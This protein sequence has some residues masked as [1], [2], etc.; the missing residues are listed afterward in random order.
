MGYTKR[1][2]WEI[3]LMQTTVQPT[4]QPTEPPEEVSGVQPTHLPILT[5]EE[6]ADYLRLPI[7]AVRDH[8]VQGLLPG[9][10]IQGEW[11]FLK[12][13]IDQWLNPSPRPL[14]K[15]SLITHADLAAAESRNDELLAL[16]RSW[17]TPDQ[18]AHQTE[19]WKHLKLALQ[20]SEGLRA[21]D[22]V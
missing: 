12:S 15:K 9:N 19:T 17:D 20:N 5:L 13:A 4:I 11:R 10:Q 1:T 2:F 21:R 22:E 6:V 16:V 18:E 3:D 7:E 14:E 8:A